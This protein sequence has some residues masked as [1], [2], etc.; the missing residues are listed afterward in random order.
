MPLDTSIPLQ[1]QAPQQNPLQTLI[2]VA[3][4]RMANAQGGALQQQIAANRATSAAY[5]QATDPTTGVV[6]NNKL[7]G[8]L[9]QDPNAAYNLP[10]VIQGIP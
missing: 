1:A 9:S 3:N 6:D 2:G 8:I 10:Q 7:V 4:L 5:Q